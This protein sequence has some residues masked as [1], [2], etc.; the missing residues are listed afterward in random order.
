MSQNSGRGDGEHAGRRAPV[1]VLDLRP[2]PCSFDPTV[3]REAA[4]RRP[5]RTN[6][7]AAALSMIVRSVSA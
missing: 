4:A 6:L 1:H 3:Q 5:D 2:R 7:V